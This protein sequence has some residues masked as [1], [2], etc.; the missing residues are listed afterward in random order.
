MLD[1]LTRRWWIVAARGLTAV[2]LGLA[3]FVARI[4]TLSL[5]VSFFGVFAIADGIF[6][7]GAGLAVDWLALFL[8]GIAGI[9]IG[10][11]TF[12]YPAAAELWFVPLV[13]AWAVVMG[14]FE[15]TAM[16]VLRQRSQ[17]SMAI[18]G[19]LIGSLGVISLLFGLGFGLR[20]D[21][22]ALTGT[23]G[24]YALVSGV[25]VT[26]IGLNVRTWPRTPAVV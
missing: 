9:S 3:L 17:G 4:E 21:V 25:L 6:V 10:G 14:A 11:F 22:G 8:E 18:G 1:E 24:A 26:A 20:P 13:V 19:Q 16:V 23:L 12:L 7:A 15:L 2:A 5:L